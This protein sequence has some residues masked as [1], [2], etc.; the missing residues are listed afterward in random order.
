MEIDDKFGLIGPFEGNYLSCTLGENCT[1]VTTGFGLTAANRAIVI[2]S[3]DG[4]PACGSAGQEQAIWYDE[5]Q[6]GPIA[7]P[8]EISEDGSTAYF[9]F[10]MPLIDVDPGQ[11]NGRPGSHYKVTESAR[12]HSYYSS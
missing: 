8:Y 12:A 5:A 2:A 3:G 9:F 11:D 4:G 6:G 1:M 10:G 7:A